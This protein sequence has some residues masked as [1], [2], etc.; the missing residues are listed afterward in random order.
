MNFQ[1]MTTVKKDVGANS[2]TVGGSS[3][4]KKVSCIFTELSLPPPPPIVEIFL[5]QLSTISTYHGK[6]L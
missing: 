5:L 3:S 2:P 6:N 1:Q 4:N